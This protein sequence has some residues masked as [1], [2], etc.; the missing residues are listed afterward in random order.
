MGDEKPKDETRL[1]TIA[2]VRA[3]I[4]ELVE[5][6]MPPHVEENQ[7]SIPGFVADLENPE[8]TDPPERRN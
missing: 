7:S 3:R 6:D 1:E 8:L 4:R 5:R 2:R